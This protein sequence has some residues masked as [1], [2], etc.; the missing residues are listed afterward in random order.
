MTEEAIIAMFLNNVCKALRIHAVPIKRSKSSWDAF[1]REITWLDNE[2][3][4]QAGGSK[5]LWK[6]SSLAV[7]IDKSEVHSPSKEELAEEI[8]QLKRQI[9]EEKGILRSS[10]KTRPGWGHGT[11]D[12]I[13]CYNCGNRGHIARS[14]QEKRNWED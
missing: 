1:L 13:Q 7:E 6:K 11:K 12:S 3:P 14:C 5:T 10:K 8:A 2:E 4:G 9:A